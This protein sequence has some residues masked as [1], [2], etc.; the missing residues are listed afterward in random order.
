MIFLG[1]YH[2]RVIKGHIDRTDQ[3]NLR[4]NLN[5]KGLK[6]DS[7]NGIELHHYVKSS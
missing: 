2:K 5:V 1:T 3:S 7:T 6:K 4:M